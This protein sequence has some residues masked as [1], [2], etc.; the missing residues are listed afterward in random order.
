MWSCWPWVIPLFICHWK[1]RR[2]SASHFLPFPCFL[3]RQSRWAFRSLFG[4]TVRRSSIHKN[5]AACSSTAYIAAT[6]Q[7]T[8]TKTAVWGPNVSAR[9]CFC[10]L[11]I[12]FFFALRCLQVI[13]PLVRHGGCQLL[14]ISLSSNIPEPDWV[15]AHACVSLARKSL[16]LYS[17]CV[18]FQVMR[19]GRWLSRDKWGWGSRGG[20]WRKDGWPDSSPI[21]R[22]ITVGAPRLCVTVGGSVCV[23]EGPRSHF[24]LKIPQIVPRFIWCDRIIN[25]PGKQWGRGDEFWLGFSFV[26]LR[27]K[28]QELF[29]L[30][31]PNTEGSMS[32]NTKKQP[33]LFAHNV[34]VKGGIGGVDVGAVSPRKQ[35]ISSKLGFVLGGVWRE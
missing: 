25:E 32:S 20:E 27:G 3:W 9:V 8:D 21:Q 1:N 15:Q 16:C 22:L 11:C 5:A 29:S 33:A 4:N 13:H 10:S 24:I 19:L 17:E 7:H 12:F 31:M 2:R 28:K 35:R 26:I 30:T 34:H 23:E 6:N 18:T 14:S